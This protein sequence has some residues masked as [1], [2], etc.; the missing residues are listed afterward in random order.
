MLGVRLDRFEPCWTNTIDLRR[1]AF[2]NDHRFKGLIIFPAAGYV[3]LALAAGRELHGAGNLQLE[4][5]EIDQPLILKQGQRR[6]IQVQAL[7]ND[8]TISINS[9]VAGEED[10]CLPHMRGR[11]RKMSVPGRRRFNLD[12]LKQQCPE[13]ITELLYPAFEKAGHDYRGAFSGIDGIWRGGDEVFSILRPLNSLVPGLNSHDLEAYLL[14]PALLDL[15]FQALFGTFLSHQQTQFKAR[16]PIALERLRLYGVPRPDAE[17]VVYARRLTPVEDDFALGDIYIIDKDGNTLVEIGNL[18]GKPPSAKSE[19]SDWLYAFEWDRQEIVHGI[20]ESWAGRVAP[21]TLSA[22]V[23]PDIPSL[24]ERFNLDQYYGEVRSFGEAMTVA[25]VWEAF[26]ELGGCWSEGRELTVKGVCT[27]LKIASQHERLT[28]RL[29]QCLESWDLLAKTGSDT[30]QVLS[31]Y[32][33]PEAAAIIETYLSKYK[34]KHP[35]F[36]LLEQCGQQLARVLRGDVDPVRVLFPNGSQELME[37]VYDRS[38]MFRPYNKIVEFVVRAMCS[39]MPENRPLRILEIG[40]GTGALASLLLANL[41]VG[42]IQYTF[43]DISPAF[44]VRAKEKFSGFGNVD[45]QV[46]DI[47]R[48]PIQQGFNPESFDLVIAGDVLHATKDLKQAIAHANELLV[49]NGMLLLLEMTSP[50]FYVDVTL[51]MLKGWWAFEDTGLRADHCCLDRDSWKKLLGECGLQDVNILTDRSDGTGIQSVISSRKPGGSVRAGDRDRDGVWF[52]FV[53][54][55]GTGDRVKEEFDKNGYITL[56]VTL[57][58]PDEPPRPVPSSSQVI[59]AGDLAEMRALFHEAAG[60]YGTIAGVVYL[61]PLD[62]VPLDEAGRETLDASCTGECLNVVNILRAFDDLDLDGGLRLVLVTRDAQQI[63]DDD[64]V[65]GV[66][67]S[68][69][70]GLGRVAEN[71]YPDCHI[72]LIDLPGAAEA[73][74]T[75][76]IYEEATQRTSRELEVALR[77]GERHVARLRRTSRER[78]AR[79]QSRPRPV[80]QDEKFY[81]DLHK[82]GD[83]SG[84]VLKPAAR[85]QPGPG[86]VEIEVHHAGLNFRDLMKAM[87]IYPDDGGT[88]FYLGDEC[89]GIVLSVGPG[90]EDFVPGDRVAAIARGFGS[91]VITPADC[92]VRIPEHLSLADAAT[93]P[94]VFCTVWHALHELAGIQRGERLLIHAA[95][96]GVGLAAVQI[97]QN[98]GAEIFATAGSD[99]K[100][101]YLSSLGVKHVLNSRSL[102][103]HDE[104]QKATDGEGVDIVLNSLSGE[105]I[106]E[107]LKL[108]RSYGR[109]VEIGKTDIYQK[110]ALNLYPFRNNLS[111]FAMDLEKLIRQHP[112][113]IRRYLHEVM[114]VFDDKTLTPLPVTAFDINDAEKAF[115]HMA[116]AKHIGKIVF[117]MHGGSPGR[118]VSEA[119]NFKGFH[120]DASYLLTGGLGGF[121][122]AVAQW[123]AAE[124]A[125]HLILAGRRAVLKDPQREKIEA[126][127]ESGCKVSV[128]SLDVVDGDKIQQVLNELCT[129]KAP[130]KGVIHM[131]MVLDD[132]AIGNQNA[133]SF[134]RVL[135]PKV[136][137]AWNLHRVTSTKDLDFFVLFSSIAAVVGNP[138]QSNYAA[139]NQF[140]DTLAYHRRARGLPALTIAWGPISDVGYLTE[141]EDIQQRFDRRGL[142]AIGTAEAIKILHGCLQDELSSAGVLFVDWLKYSSH[143]PRLLSS[144]RFRHLVVSSANVMP[145][146]DSGGRLLADLKGASSSK[147]QELVHKWLAEQLAR[148]L[149]CEL[150]KIDASRSLNDI[151]VD[152]LMAVELSALIEKSLGIS[153]P[154]MELA[155]T[156][157]IGRLAARLAEEATGNIDEARPAATSAA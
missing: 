76:R 115:R 68:P 54:R 104:I 103:F 25:F 1:H 145:I 11:I 109:F 27:D 155:Q 10:G 148:I 79:A 71:E 36:N 153:I 26:V 105:F 46:L 85:P 129:E 59:A 44:F 128:V 137:G 66:L 117:D 47:E 142:H 83:L 118:A 38:S 16:L 151:G 131:V 14:H 100:R 73:I 13:N 8:G 4:N 107:S 91:V 81:L 49:S 134:S 141:R 40:A 52:L 9:R 32:T 80:K 20:D 130:L 152:S 143:F 57:A 2:L 42:R 55:H 77:G 50:S 64:I 139:A 106:Q 157:T 135:D 98:A 132:R 22:I 87:D 110:Q 149:D 41:P 35:E 67:S 78:L 28:R 150:E 60:R 147:R 45:Y 136:K 97:A 6:Q 125:G 138:G 133:G 89:S 7:A 51:G 24:A 144:S 119:P 123:M 95:A 111:F 37:P 101:A 122:L 108:L 31:V 61:R 3:E 94:L 126:I 70:W 15:G 102:D 88:H 53:D 121:G 62:A 99:E 18:A 93:I 12:E 21:G 112:K 127:E 65:T 63:K 34:E 30:W 82:P 69:L 17:H 5:M 74:D 154:S 23:Q 124:G 48:S 146:A 120:K 29:L 114:Q 92:V 116:Q 75:A 72:T 86:E 39:G 113:R 43:T 33:G 156:T 84:F 140:L 58:G 19:Q 96:G 90:V 56:P